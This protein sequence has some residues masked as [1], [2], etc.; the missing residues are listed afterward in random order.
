MVPFEI[1]RDGA[2]LFSSFNQGEFE[3]SDGRGCIVDRLRCNGV[4]DCLD[5]SDEVGCGDGPSGRFRVPCAFLLPC[6]KLHVPSI[7]VTR[8]QDLTTTS[9]H[10][11]KSTIIDHISHTDLQEKSGWSPTQTGKPS[12]RDVRSSS[13]AVT[14]V[15]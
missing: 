13:N 7:V 6:K 9:R 10:Y 3:C 8:K 11:Q 12:K 1:H 14:K 5:K 2:V 4:H 15:L